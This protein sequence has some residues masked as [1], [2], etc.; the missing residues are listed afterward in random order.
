MIK[1]DRSTHKKIFLTTAPTFLQGDAVRALQRDELKPCR[2]SRKISARDR[3]HLC[4]I[5]LNRFLLDESNEQ[6]VKQD[7]E[8][9]KWN[10]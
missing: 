3:R 8:G 1:L 7:R 4:R 2:P 9:R 10:D 6:K 5:S